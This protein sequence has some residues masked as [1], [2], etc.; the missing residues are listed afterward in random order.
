MNTL[1]ALFVD[2]VKTPMGMYQVQIID[3]AG[4]APTI[5]EV[6]RSK[7]DSGLKHPYILSLFTNQI[8]LNILVSL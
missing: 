8:H 7:Y 1:R 2:S 4:Q 6:H 5:V 3:I